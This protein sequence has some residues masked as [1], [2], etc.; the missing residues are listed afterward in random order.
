MENA[1]NSRRTAVMVRPVPF[2]EASLATSPSAENCLLAKTIP[3]VGTTSTKPI[4]HNMYDSRHDGI[5]LDLE[6]LFLDDE[7]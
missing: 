2:S 3:I 6:L 7:V 4:T 5:V 1:H